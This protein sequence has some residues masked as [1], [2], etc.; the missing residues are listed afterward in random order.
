MVSL[1]FGVVLLLSFSFSFFSIPYATFRLSDSHSVA[2]GALARAS[3]KIF[4]RTY[5]FEHLSFHGSTSWITPFAFLA[6]SISFPPKFAS[7]EGNVHML[8]GTR[9]RIDLLIDMGR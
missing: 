9:C 4:G 8:N 6:V 2:I 5:I 7:V 3:M 1:H